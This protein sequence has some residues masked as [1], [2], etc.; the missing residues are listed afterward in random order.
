MYLIIVFIALAVVIFLAL[1]AHKNSKNEMLQEAS[2]GSTQQTTTSFNLFF[3]ENE[4]EF[5]AQVQ[6]LLAELSKDALFHLNNRRNKLV[7]IKR[8]LLDLYKYQENNLSEELSKLKFPKLFNRS[9]KFRNIYEIMQFDI[10][11]HQP[12]RFFTIPQVDQ[13]NGDFARLYDFLVDKGHEIEYREQIQRIALAYCKV[14]NT[15]RRI[16]K[17][18]NDLKSL[19]AL[20]ASNAALIEAIRAMG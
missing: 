9:S 19:D 18:E 14:Q 4:A 1:K 2:L 11:S 20:E 17:V 13:E 16:I 5:E 3:E 6:L 10:S 7:D 12:V 8:H 15:M